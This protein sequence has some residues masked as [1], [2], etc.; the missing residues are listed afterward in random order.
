MLLNKR[1]LIKASR[2]KK[3]QQAHFKNEQVKLLQAFEEHQQKQVELTRKKS[4][5]E[6]VAE[7]F[8]RQLQNESMCPVIIANANA[9]I[10]QEKTLVEEA[11]QSSLAAKESLNSVMGSY[12]DTKNNLKWLENKKTFYQKEFRSEV[13]KIES[14]ELVQL[15]GHRGKR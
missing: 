1:K 11:E 6:Q 3:L 12:L 7:S 13:E 10:A 5:L 9:V 4:K 14:E 8:N 2:F 15:Y